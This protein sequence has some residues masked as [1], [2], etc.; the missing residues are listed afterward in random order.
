MIWGWLAVY[1]YLDVVRTQIF[2]IFVE[3]SCLRLVAKQHLKVID[4]E[5]HKP[6][7]RSTNSHELIRKI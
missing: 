2:R 1:S 7:P 3:F 4:A 6:D 5:G